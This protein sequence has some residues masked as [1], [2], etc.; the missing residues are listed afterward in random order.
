MLELQA[1]DASANG[2]SHYNPMIS[3]QFENLEPLL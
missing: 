1:R 2:V 3:K